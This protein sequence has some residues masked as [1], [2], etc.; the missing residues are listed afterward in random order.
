VLRAATGLRKVRVRQ[1]P[2]TRGG[3]PVNPRGRAS[4]RA[5]LTR[6]PADTVGEQA[7]RVAEDLASLF[8]FGSDDELGAALIEALKALSPGSAAHYARRFSQLL[9]GVAAHWKTDP[10]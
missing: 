10:G 6:T 2:A 8:Q 7:K 5:R 3:N 4:H 1:S 9:L